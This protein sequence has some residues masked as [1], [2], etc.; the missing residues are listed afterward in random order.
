MFWLPIEKASKVP[1]IR[2]I[3]TQIKANILS[4]VLK[5]KERLPSSRELANELKVS[6]NVVVV[7]YELLYVEGYV[8]GK[9]GAGTFVASGAFL[10]NVS[11]E[12]K[13]KTKCTSHHSKDRD[14]IDFKPGVPAL[15][16]FPRT[17]WLRCYNEVVKGAPDSLFG[18]HKP[19]GLLEL[20][21]SLVNYLY[22]TRGIRCSA[23]QI[24]ITTGAAQG[25]SLCSQLSIFDQDQIYLEDPSSEDLYNIFT[26]RGSR[27]QPIEVDELGVVTSQLYN[28]SPAKLIYVTPSHQYPLGGML[29]IQRRIELI[30]YARSYNAYIVEDDYDS[31]FRYTTAP[32]SSLHELDPNHVIYIGT[33]SKTLSPALRLGY[34]IL[35]PHLVQESRE[36]KRFTD[37]H[38]TIIDQSVLSL[39]IE[40]GHLERHIRK[41]SKLYKKRRELL[42]KEL[43]QSFKGIEIHGASTG[44]HFVIEFPTIKY[45]DTILLK[46]KEN[47]V[48]IHPLKKY[49]RKNEKLL[50]KWVLGFGNVSEEQIKTGME[51]LK[52]AL[53]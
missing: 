26:S 29:P 5:E 53:S 10:E 19:E 35:P 28:K 52:R 38:S 15:D 1:I 34:M 11:R 42:I 39:F 8:E 6:R 36:I 4:G 41:S 48:M 25:L 31:E 45:C 22:R 46:L 24:I 40:Q 44:L 16:I 49:S 18:Y 2:Q 51:R 33:F 47:K 23:D 37:L 12:D 20:R 3:Y 27:V 14:I 32:V 13:E 21:E 17:K 43:K 50:N 9:I 30:M 7:A